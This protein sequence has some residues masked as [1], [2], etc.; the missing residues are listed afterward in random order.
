MEAEA[1]NQRPTSRKPED[2]AFKQQ[3]L[4][5]W[6]PILTPKW[7]ISIF[8]AIGTIFI[9]IGV[10]LKQASDSVVE[11]SIQ[12]GGDGTQ[13]PYATTCD[14]GYDTATKVCN[15]TFT[16]D[17]DMDGPVYV[18]YHLT[19]FYQNHRRYV[20]SLSSDQLRGLTLIG[21]DDDC[22]PLTHNGSYALNPCGLIANSLFNDVITLESNAYSMSESGIS[23]ESDREKKFVQ[24]SGFSYVT[25]GE[26]TSCTDFNCT[27]EEA[28]DSDSY[29][30]C[31]P[32]TDP[33]GTEYFYYYPDDNKIQYLYETFPQVVSPI[34][35]VKNEHFIVWMRT[36]GLPSFRK[37]YG[38]IESD[39]SSGDTL[40]FTISQN[41][42]VDTFEGTK[43]LVISTTSWFGGKNPF[44][45]VAYIVVGTIC[46]ALGI[47]FTIKH[48]LS[49]RKLGDTRYLIWSGKSD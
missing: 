8:L 19:N 28:F 11:Y 10:V 38:K 29:D 6:Q 16:L 41:F 12:Y 36:A 39:L 4:K 26:D 7:V 27:C 17:K 37:L 15:V 47:A 9:V 33:S 24:P 44:L 35:G 23:W 1:E 42:L 3:R 48:R 13:E 5:A 21:S 22:D 30:G 31:K 25:I 49:P 46:C 14:M 43:S 45:G 40:T 2:T 34:E 32:Y 20:K 18:Y